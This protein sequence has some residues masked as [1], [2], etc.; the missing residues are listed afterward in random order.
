MTRIEGALRDQLAEINVTGSTPE[1]N[2]DVKAAFAAIEVPRKDADE[3]I[4]NAICSGRFQFVSL[5]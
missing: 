2:A 4:S 5:V 3:E 1:I